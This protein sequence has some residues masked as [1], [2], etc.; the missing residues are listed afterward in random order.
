MDFE[1][2]L[3]FDRRAAL[4]AGQLSE[5]LGQ[6]I[7]YVIRIGT[8]LADAHDAQH[9]TLNSGLTQP[10]TSAM[11]SN[12]AIS[13]PIFAVSSAI[14]CA[15]TSMHAPPPEEAL[16]V[17]NAA[18][19]ARIERRAMRRSMNCGGREGRPVNEGAAWR[20]WGQGRRAGG[21][22]IGGILPLWYACERRRANI[23]R[24]AKK[25]RRNRRAHRSSRS[26]PPLSS[27]I[28]RE[29]AVD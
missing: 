13:S 21:H 6:P 19:R 20:R 2:Y 27:A 24:F 7:L 5:K 18:H 22:A 25:L 8:P 23:S 1:F 16:K 4:R 28:L 9:L 12:C 17:P 26:S 10:P 11:A 14:R 15:G 3:W 29:L